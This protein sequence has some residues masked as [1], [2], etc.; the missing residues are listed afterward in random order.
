MIKVTE[1]GS[2]VVILY[3]RVTAVINDLA[4]AA[5]HSPYRIAQCRWAGQMQDMLQKVVYCSALVSRPR[6]PGRSVARTATEG[7]DT[8]VM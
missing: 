4:A 2:C 3:V 5:G 8:V 1:L 7:T 6:G